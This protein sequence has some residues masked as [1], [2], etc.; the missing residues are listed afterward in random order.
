MLTAS[1]RIS[2][3]ANYQER[4]ERLFASE[5]RNDVLEACLLEEHMIDPEAKRFS[6]VDFRRCVRA[7]LDPKYGRDKLGFDP[8][9]LLLVFKLILLF[10]ELWFKFSRQGD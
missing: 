10:V 7:R 6:Q 3:R 9:T 2:L 5:L 8:L 1:A 4:T